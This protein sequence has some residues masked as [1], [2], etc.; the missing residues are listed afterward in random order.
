LKKNKP[1][2]N[3]SSSAGT[4]G[5]RQEE[6]SEFVRNTLN[7]AKSQHQRGQLQAA[8]TLYRQV[9][10]A[11]PEHLRG[12]FLLG[13]V[14][15]QLGQYE[16]AE[17]FLRK[18][19]EINPDHTPARMELGNLAYLTGEF[20]TAA[21]CFRTVTDHEPENP[22]AH[23]QLANALNLLGRADE[24]I[25]EELR[26]IEIWP[27]FADALINL[28]DIY[29]QLGRKEEAIASLEKAL[30]IN[31]KAT[32]AWLLLVMSGGC[33]NQPDK[34][35]AMKRLLETGVLT[36]E[37]RAQLAFALGRAFENQGKHAEAFEYIERGN[38]ARRKGLRFSLQDEMEHF[39]KIRAVFDAEFLGRVPD[40]RPQG[41][42][43]IIIIGMP[44]SGT[45]LVEQILSSHPDV[46]GSG[47]LVFLDR[48]C[49]KL[50]SASGDKFPA[51][52]RSMTGDEFFDLGTQ[53][54][55]LLENQTDGTP[56]ITDKYPLN[57][58][59]IGMIRRALPH[60][61]IIHCRRDA[62]DNCVSIYR[63]IFSGQLAFAYDQEE[64]GGYYRLYENLMAH[65][66]QV[67]PG[68][69]FDIDYEALVTDTEPRIRALLDYCGLTFDPACL[70]FHQTERPVRTMSSAQVRR[71]IY[72]DSIS[73]WKRYE[74][75][76]ERLRAALGDPHTSTD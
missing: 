22:N 26:A 2:G 19:L 16:Q 62:L 66:H 7:L 29:Q 47:E 52:A 72:R 44:R 46:H 71:P 58:L 41:T 48:L 76:V 28:G 25:E 12:T 51:C 55:E 56:F 14:L 33:E 67:M 6:Q 31:P 23:D 17:S 68:E 4:G 30:A 53:Y 39:A 49:Q 1:D 32:N 27:D 57:F 65:W 35:E 50:E 20:E 21:E 54:L 37:Q 15:V 59:F 5:I 9:I 74:R 34:V 64:L 36:D 75:Q 63:S 43:P 3:S 61:K 40:V 38:R 70:S 60:A 69:I 8:E 45:S 13:A 73:S 10:A 24:A 42:T 11:E 18:S